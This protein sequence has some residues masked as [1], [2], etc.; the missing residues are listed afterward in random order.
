MVS[1]FWGGNYLALMDP[2]LQKLKTV[3]DTILMEAARDG[4]QGVVVMMICLIKDLVTS[5]MGQ[6]ILPWIQTRVV[7]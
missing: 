1:K 6:T 3:T 4:C 5:F 2:M 7:P